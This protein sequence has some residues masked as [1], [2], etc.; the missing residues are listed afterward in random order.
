MTPESTYRLLSLE[1]DIERPR[2]LRTGSL[3]ACATELAEVIQLDAVACNRS[4]LRI[5]AAVDTDR[6]VEIVTATTTGNQP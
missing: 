4:V 2:V 1:S 3:E 5:V 6:A